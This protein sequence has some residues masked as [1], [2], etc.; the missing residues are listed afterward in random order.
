MAPAGGGGSGT[1][2]SGG[3]MIPSSASAV[4]D[5]ADD[6]QTIDSCEYIWAA[7]VGFA[8]RVSDS[9]SCDLHRRELL[10]LLATCFSQTI[11]VSNKGLEEDPTAAGAAAAANRWVS[12]FTSSENRHALPLFTSLLNTVCGYDPAGILP[13]NH[14][15]FSDSREELVEIAIQVRKPFCRVLSEGYTCS[16]FI[17]VPLVVKVLV[18]TLDQDTPTAANALTDDPSAAAALPD[19]LF[20]NYLSR[21]HREEDFGFI[22]K[23]VTRLLMNPLVQTYLPHSQRK[24]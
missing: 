20:L 10:R 17:G 4:R 6:L 22:L 1:S 12:A 13:Y 24:V 9:P 23:G 21:I 8:G 15:I 2:K 16:F 3:G 11:Y 19:N 7:G 14:L 5:E 18:I